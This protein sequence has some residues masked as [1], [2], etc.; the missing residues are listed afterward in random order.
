M[1]IAIP[2]KIIGLIR[3]QAIKERPNEACG[4]LAGNDTSVAARYAM[5]NIDQSPD[6]YSFDPREQ[7]E[8]LRWARGKNLQLIATYHSHPISPARM[9]EEDIRL[10]VDP[11]VF[12][13]IYSLLDSEIRAYRVGAGKLITEFNVVITDND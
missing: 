10:A 7:F 5:R 2:S 3:E 4:Y 9:S 8:A 6:H 1:D 13:C 12:Y 11:N